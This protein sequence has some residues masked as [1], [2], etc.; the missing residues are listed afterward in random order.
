MRRQLGKGFQ[1][2]FLGLLL[3]LVAVDLPAKEFVHEPTGLVFPDH[4]GAA[5][6]TEILDYE[7]QHPGLGVGVRYRFDGI[8]FDVYIYDALEGRTSGISESAFARQFSQASNDIARRSAEVGS[9]EPEPRFLRRDPYLNI[10][11][12]R[13]GLVAGFELVEDGVVKSSFLHLTVRNNHY[14]K[15]RATYEFTPENLRA[16]YE[17]IRELSGILNK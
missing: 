5:E 6:R 4:L 9:P 11:D 12:N 8:K 16:H 3:G 10:D 2:L 15:I 17:M 1:T 14:V 13:P 7:T